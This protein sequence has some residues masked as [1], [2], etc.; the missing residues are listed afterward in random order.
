MRYGRR[1]TSR[2]GI[3]VNQSTDVALNLRLEFVRI[4]PSK[5]GD[6]EAIFSGLL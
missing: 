1:E 5:E 2:E 6:R 4:R 3:F